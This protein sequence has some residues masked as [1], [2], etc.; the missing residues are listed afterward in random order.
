[1]T[2][3]KGFGCRA[4]GQ[5]GRVLV[6]STPDFQAGRDHRRE[7]RLMTPA[8][9]CSAQVPYWLDHVA[10]PIIFT[11]FGALLG[12]AFGRLRDWIEDRKTKTAF[13]KAIRIELSTI[14]EN[15]K[16]SLKDTLENKEQFEKGEHK[17]I[18]AVTAFLTTVYSS[19]LGKLKDVSDPRVIDAIRFY[20]NLSNLE[21]VRS[22]FASASFDLV[23]LTENEAAKEA[24]I[25]VVYGSALN[26]VIK[27]MTDLLPDVDSLIEKLPK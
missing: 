5:P 19:Q 11:F 27:R 8:Q 1:M 24:G 13:L 3:Q 4:G 21:R 12:F 6:P 20:G 9:A 22:Y 18:H 7:E 16:G 25:I 23:R 10:V 15:L 26:E 2:R 17:V 14:R